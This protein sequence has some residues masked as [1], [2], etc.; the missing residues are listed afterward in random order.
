M[1]GARPLRPPSTMAEPPGSLNRQNGEGI[2]G[3]TA[4]RPWLVGVCLLALAACDDDVGPLAAPA[5]GRIA[6]GTADGP[7]LG[8]ALADPA[9]DG[10][11]SDGAAP[12][13][14]R[15]AYAVRVVTLR[16]APVE[17]DLLWLI[18][19]A[20]SMCGEQFT[21]PEAVGAFVDR[22]LE[23]SPDLDLAM[24]TT[25]TDMD[26]ARGLD[27]RFVAAPAIAVPT[28]GCIDPRNGLPYVPPTDECEARAAAGW[29]PAIATWGG[30][31]GRGEAG[32]ECAD[33]DCKRRGL[34]FKA[35]CLTTVG[36]RGSDFPAGVAAL[37][38][39]TAC[40]GPNKAL[41]GHCCDR[42]ADPD[43]ARFW[44][45]GAAR[46][47]VIIADGDDCSA[48]QAFARD[49]PGRCAW[50][51]ADLEPIPAAVDHLRSLG[52][53]PLGVFVWSAPP[54][55]VA[56]GS[57]AR[58]RPYAPESDPAMCDPRL[59]PGADFAAWQ[60][61]CCPPDEP[62]I[63]PPRST[64]TILAEDGAAATPRYRALALALGSES[65]DIT[66][67]DPTVGPALAE[68]VAAF[69]HP[70]RRL[71]LGPIDGPIRFTGRCLDRPALPGSPCDEPWAA[72]PGLDLRVD[73]PTCAG[74]AVELPPGTAPGAEIRLEFEAPLP[75]GPPAAACALPAACAAVESAQGDGFAIDYGWRCASPG[76]GC[77]RGWCVGEPGREPDCTIEC[78]SPDDCA[79]GRCLPLH[80]EGCAAAGG[81]CVCGW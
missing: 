7:M 15:Q 36:V 4:A 57:S 38:R 10:G 72:Q 30:A 22:L 53:E 12:D 48:A 49:D 63:G 59:D 28:P 37:R 34:R 62:C 60:A 51:A 45:P 44:R 6:D 23:V 78:R 80:P 64:C 77:A 25:L 5:D 18:E 14:S 13:A 31:P 33:L 70:R 67:C 81:G 69:A 16:P 24:T 40:D 3:E 41:L 9:A 52:P 43:C 47:V 2:M 61:G 54:A 39:A 11:A 19:D 56:D 21:V 20:S 35:H 58:W 73:D 50:Q 32:D 26:A 79:I 46:A 55:S 71:C 42:V 29:L 76:A 65:P 1:P 66:V 17:L 27:G 8:D 68:Q 75:G 74:V